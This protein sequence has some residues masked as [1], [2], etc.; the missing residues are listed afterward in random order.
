MKFDFFLA[1]A[2][3]L[4]VPPSDGTAKAAAPVQ[5]AE[6]RATAAPAVVT[7]ARYRRAVR[8]APYVAPRRVYVAPRRVYRRPYVAPRRVYGYRPYVGYGWGWY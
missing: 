3:L 1:A 4:A 7:P 5:T 8:R 2:L 6:L